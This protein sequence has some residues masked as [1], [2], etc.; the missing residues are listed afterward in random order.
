M[1]ILI[2][3]LG[4][5]VGVLGSVLVWFPSYLTHVFETLTMAFL[6]EHLLVLFHFLIYI[7]P[8]RFTAVTQTIHYFIFQFISDDPKA[9]STSV[10]RG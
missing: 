1:T 4:K 6:K 10:H 9:Q 7:I 3:S 8:P 2:D 5:L